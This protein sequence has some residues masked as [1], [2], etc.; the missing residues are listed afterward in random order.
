MS[1]L[2]PQNCT[3]GYYLSKTCAG[4]EY[5]PNEC[6]VCSQDVVAAG[7]RSDQYYGGCG[8]YNN[9]RCLDI[10]AC[11]TGQYRYGKT[12]K[13]PGICRNCSTCTTSG[14]NQSRACGGFKDTVCVGVR[15]GTNLTCASSFETKYYCDY[16]IGK[17]FPTCGICPSGYDSDGQFCMECP[18]GKTCD[19]RGQVA[20][21]GQCAALKIS[22]CDTVVG[23]AKC[24]VGACNP[25]TDESKE[26]TRGSYMVTNMAAECAPYFQCAAG[27]Y[28]RF[29]DIGVVQCEPCLEILPAYAIWVTAGLSVNDGLSCMWECP[30]WLSRLNKNNTGCELLPDREYQIE[31]IRAGWWSEGSCGIGRTSEAGAAIYAADCLDCPTLPDGASW[32]AGGVQCEW[33]CATATGLEKRGGECVDIHAGL[34]PLCKT[35]GFTLAVGGG[36]CVA[37]G[38]PWNRAGYSKNGWDPVVITGTGNNSS[39]A[40]AGVLAFVE[41]Q[42]LILRSKSLPYGLRGRHTIEEVIA[43]S[44]NTIVRSWT[45][46][47]PICS[48]TRLRIGMNDF[49][50]GAVCNQS[51]LVYLKL[52]TSNPRSGLLIGSNKRGWANGFKTQ[53]LFQSELYVTK[54][55]RGNNVFVLD[56]W[57]CMLREVVITGEPG[58]Y[59]TRVYSV[60][61]LETKF[62]NSKLWEPKCYGEGSLASPRRFWS[63]RFQWVVFAV[64]DG[65]YQFNTDTRELVFMDKESNLILPAE[66][67][68][69]V[70]APDDFTLLLGFRDGSTSI[71]K[72]LETRCPPDTT[73]L[74][75]GDCSTGCVLAEGRFVDQSSGLCIDCVQTACGVGQEF[76]PCSRTQQGYCKDCDNGDPGI[77]IEPGS[78]DKL[79]KRFVPP[80]Q[81]GFYKDVRGSYCSQCPSLT[82]TVYAG[83][84]RLEQCK[85][86]AGLVR[87]NGLCVAEPLY[88]FEGLT[89][90]SELACAVDCRL[91]RNARLLAN[92]GVAC[93]WECN[94]GYYHDTLAGWSDKCRPCFVANTS[95]VVTTRGDNDSPWSCET[96]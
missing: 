43:G 69:T 31:W 58:G 60:H 26:I 91:P 17:D 49:M 89:A 92:T 1:C 19:R 36:N 80:C 44:S 56:R 77:F 6:T 53:A 48:M 65:L 52:S 51:F 37:T 82:S 87:K 88:E 13:T 64:D 74:P 68:T 33:G 24:V 79:F 76:V 32:I 85:C 42:G 12:Y 20:C 63:L 47:G 39:M 16:G 81:A 35:R 84:V 18:E 90:G 40:T 7:C 55:E 4:T 15:C 57:N 5:Y 93:G 95:A 62:V 9:S 46:Y 22:E 14:L 96:R 67:L 34:G 3:S 21:E 30:G 94:M 66:S 23:Y 28:K 2:V 61:G 45:V 73:S 59:L 25:T 38:Y 8:G 71:V 75:G 27:Y 11:P 10:A 72:A 78:C 29:Y 83:A 50:I 54:G 41:L 86:L 70:S